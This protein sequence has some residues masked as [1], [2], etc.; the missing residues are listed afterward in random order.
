MQ[1]TE[2]LKPDRRCTHGAKKN[3]ERD[4]MAIRVWLSPRDVCALMATQ[5]AVRRIKAML[6]RS[7]QVD[8]NSPEL[9]FAMASFSK[10]YSQF[11][12]SCVSTQ[13]GEILDRH[14][15]VKVPR[16][17]YLIL[18]SLGFCIFQTEEGE[19]P[20]MGP[21]GHPVCAGSGSD[22]QDD[23]HHGRELFGFRRFFGHVGKQ[24]ANVAKATA[25][26]IGGVS[27]GAGAAISQIP[28]ALSSGGAVGV[29]TW[30]AQNRG[31]ILAPDEAK[32]MDR[33]LEEVFHKFGISE[34]SE[35]FDWPH[36]RHQ[37]LMADIKARV[38]PLEEKWEAE[39]KRIALNELVRGQG[40]QTYSQL[41]PEQKVRVDR[42]LESQIAANKAHS[43]KIIEGLLGGLNRLFSGW[44]DFRHD[45]TARLEAQSKSRMDKAH[46]TGR[47][48]ALIEPGYNKCK[49]Q[50]ETNLQPARNRLKARC[51]KIKEYAVGNDDWTTFDELLDPQLN[52]IPYTLTPVGPV[53]THRGQSEKKS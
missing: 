24:T 28:K 30:L 8:V 52:P 39:H 42:K 2:T 1:R 19:A 10:F 25:Y 36:E 15:L 44:E 33:A 45:R 41:T 20:L 5:S 27:S 40:K 26:G 50:I 31:P 13:D 23:A 14:R 16:M 37:L 29:R 48:I 34:L 17:V 43:R 21:G 49:G 11:Y 35:T 3:V 32:L 53:Q 38:T 7:L 9:L 22:A 6:A 4:K 12:N 51:D 46:A 18:K 47:K